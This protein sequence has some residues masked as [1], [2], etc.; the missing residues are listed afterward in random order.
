MTQPRW[1]SLPW[2]CPTEP[3]GGSIYPKMDLQ[4]YWLAAANRRVRERETE[5]DLR[6]FKKPLK[7]ICFEGEM[8]PAI[9]GCKKMKNKR[10]E[11]EKGEKNCSS[12]QSKLVLLLWSPNCC[13]QSISWVYISATCDCWQL[14]CPC[15]HVW[16]AL[17]ATFFYQCF[18]TQTLKNTKI[19][20]NWSTLL[21]LNSS[22]PRRCN[23][24]LYD[25]TRSTTGTSL[26][27]AHNALRQVLAFWDHLEF[28]H[29]QIKK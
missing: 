2:Q 20:I 15:N 8:C 7:C 23:I 6:I 26:S 29:C 17:N 14:L 28:V 22:T 4:L 12:A 21:L 16:K 27:V 25:V 5:T 3:L 9:A 18:L 24:A 13:C 19:H 1:V 11:E 10:K